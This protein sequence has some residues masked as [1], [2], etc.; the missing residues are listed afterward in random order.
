MSFNYGIQAIQTVTGNPHIFGFSVNQTTTDATL[1]EVWRGSTGAEQ[2]LRLSQ[3]GN[4]QVK[5]LLSFIDTPSAGVTVSS[6]ALVLQQNGV[7]RVYI[8]EKNGS[9]EFGQIRFGHTA[10]WSKT[11]QSAFL[12]GDN[13]IKGDAADDTTDF[14]GVLF[15]IDMDMTSG[16]GTPASLS[17]VHVDD[18]SSIN[19]NN[20]SASFPVAAGVSIGRTAITRSAG[21]TLTVAA[22]LYIAGTPIVTGFSANE[23]VGIYLNGATDIYLSGGAIRFGAGLQIN[24]VS[25]QVYTVTNVTP[26]R[27]YD[28]NAT[29]IDEIADVLGTL[30]SDLIT[31]GIFQ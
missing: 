21:E 15:D 24:N 3:E 16:F 20:A 1:L 22:S 27:T 12:F 9:S 26:D 31:L 2:R 8:D 11:E 23:E 28:A 7:Q 19:L 6:N 30:L 14:A 4:L 10:N 29:T 17:I 18:N 5:G 25:Q 13:F